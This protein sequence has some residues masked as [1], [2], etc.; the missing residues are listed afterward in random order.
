MTYNRYINEFVF[1]CSDN[2]CKDNVQRLI[3]NFL[4]Y[5]A[6][7]SDRPD[8]LLRTIVAALKH[9]CSA[10]FDDYNPFDTYMNRLLLALVKTETKRPLQRTK[11]MPVE[12]FVALFRTWADNDNLSIKKLRQKTVALIALTALCRPSDLAPKAIFKRSQISENAD[13][14]LTVNFFGIKNDRN[15]Q[16]FEIR[17]QKSSDNKVDPVDC[18]LTYLTRT[19][20]LTT[21]D[22]PVFLPISGSPPLKQVDSSTIASDLRDII[23]LAGLP[24]HFTPRCFRPT[25][26]TVAVHEGGN[27]RDIRQL[28]RW[29]TEEVFY[30]HYVYPNSK[31]NITDS[32][33]KSD[34]NLFDS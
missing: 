28:G 6:K 8:S 17:I 5:K 11:I 24:S 13:G 23:R 12:P 25:G 29:K 1:F 15:M 20:H 21:P 19:D 7:G 34:L 10:K 26:A 33:L 22:G 30:Q 14:S 3:I 4:L 16:G 27:D 31:T 18:L 9:F 32:I 2:I